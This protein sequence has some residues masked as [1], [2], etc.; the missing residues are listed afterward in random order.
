MDGQTIDPILVAEG[1]ALLKQD[2]NLA[3]KWGD[4]VLRVMPPGSTD[5]ETLVEWAERIGW[6]ETGRSITTLLN[7]RTVAL[8]WPPETRC[9][10]ASFTVHAELA[11]MPTR[12]DVIH[13]GLTKRQARIMAGKKPEIASKEARGEVVANLLGDPEVL[14]QL[15]ENPELAKVIR[16][17]SAEISSRLEAEADAD[18]AEWT[19]GLHR[20]DTWYRVLAHLSRSHREAVTAVQL[21]AEVDG[22]EGHRAEALR[23]ARR[24]KDAADITLAFF[25]GQATKETL[26]DALAAWTESES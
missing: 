26:D 25:E 6:T 9:E 5:R 11:A 12:F 7:F 3:W 22:L 10:G 14:A 23:L 20:G 17:A 15:V 19:P 13:A 16:R 1:R 18:R 24:N 8:A 21:A 2:G 4:L